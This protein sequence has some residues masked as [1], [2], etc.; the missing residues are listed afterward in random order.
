M[1]N[2]K[3]RMYAA[4][5][6][7]SKLGVKFWAFHD[8]LAGCSEAVYSKHMSEVIFYKRLLNLRTENFSS[9][10]LV[11]YAKLYKSDNCKCTSKLRKQSK[12]SVTINSCPCWYHIHTPRVYSHISL[13]TSGGSYYLRWHIGALIL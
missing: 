11:F 7:M 6:F 13:F 9:L 12:H 3:R 1:L 5:E 8:R 2:A 10:F 4:F